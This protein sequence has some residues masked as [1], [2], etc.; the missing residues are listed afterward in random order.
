MFPMPRVVYA[1]SND[2]LIFKFLSYV[3]PNL[4]TPISASIFTGALAGMQL[5]KLSS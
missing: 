3:L 2:G 1:M 4:K 5:T